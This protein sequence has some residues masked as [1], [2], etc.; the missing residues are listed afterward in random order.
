ML[1]NLFLF[2]AAWWIGDVWRT[3]REREIELRES[4]IQL[5]HEREEN[6]RRAVLN[7]RVRIARELHDV[8]AHHVSVIGIQAGVARKAMSRWPE[9]AQEALSLI[10]IS[11]R[12]AVNELQRLLGILR[13]GTK[14]D[15][16]APQPSLQQLDNLIAEVKEAG[17]QVE[18]II[19]GDKRPLPSGVDLSA[20]RIIQEAL[21]NTIKHA[22][23]ATATVTM[24]Y[25]E[26]TIELEIADTGRGHAQTGEPVITGTGLLGMKERVNLHGGEFEAGNAPGGG[27]LVRVKLPLNGIIS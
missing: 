19:E 10:E 9:K 15:E 22:G 16:T 14:T 7:E 24:N 27:F 8:V 3:R 6:A 20:Y 2:G 17:L 25:Q 13:S 23:P 18:L 4:N 21:T 12:Q 11:S 1:L 5:K 26:D